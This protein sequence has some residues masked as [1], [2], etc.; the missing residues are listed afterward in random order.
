MIS[1]GTTQF[2]MQSYDGLIKSNASKGIGEALGQF[3]KDVNALANDWTA[4]EAQREKTKAQM[5]ENQYA[6]DTHDERVK[7]AGLKN[8]SLEETIKGQ[9][10]ENLYAS[11]THDERVRAV[12][13]KN[14]STEE[15]ITGQRLDNQA[16]RYR[17][18]ITSKTK[19][20]HI[21]AVNARNVLNTASDNYL[22]DQTR[23]Q[24]K[25]IQYQDIFV[26]DANGKFRQATPEE[27]A[28]QGIRKYKNTQD[29]SYNQ[30]DAMSADANNKQVALNRQSITG[31]AGKNFRNQEAQENLRLQQQAMQN[32]SA[33]ERENRINYYKEQMMEALEKGEINEHELN[34]LPTIM[35]TDSKGRTYEVKNPFHIDFNNANVKDPY[36]HTQNINMNANM[37]MFNGQQGRN[38][39]LI[40]AL[41]DANTPADI[42]QKVAY[43]V[44]QMPHIKAAFKEMQKY[45]DGSN[46]L[47]KMGDLIMQSG[48]KNRAYEFLG[49]IGKVFPGTSQTEI[50][51]VQRQY[52][53]DE[54]LIKGMTKLLSGSLSDRDMILLDRLL[55][56]MFSEDASTGEIKIL[57]LMDSQLKHYEVQISNSG[58]SLEGWKIL[59]PAHYENYMRLK[60]NRDFLSQKYQDYK[61]LPVHRDKII[62]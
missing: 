14:K 15:Y 50:Q 19:D 35:R 60:N 9:R 44:L 36:G 33:Q 31:S 4:R 29:S 39:E 25:S 34:T 47:T 43:Q 45:T 16:S 62:G 53:N 37:N 10:L 7:T 23:L 61:G 41:N 51:H 46:S 57:N 38:A 3:G 20:K 18:Y 21:Q 24:H 27:I 42:K 22:T 26:K 54:I 52:L 56:K 13:L 5:L 59:H 1:A 40:S 8:Q 11:D 58:V 17:N 30:H 32:Q 48:D 49:M 28:N 2:M 6:L 55:P 12:G